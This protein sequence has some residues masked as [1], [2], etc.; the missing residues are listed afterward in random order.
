MNHT[1]PVLFEFTLQW[2]SETAN[3]CDRLFTSQGKPGTNSVTFFPAGELVPAQEN[4]HIATFPDHDFERK[5]R[6]LTIAPKIGRFYPQ[7]Y[8]WNALK[9]NRGNFQPFRIIAQADGKLTGDLNH[10]LARYPLTLTVRYGQTHTPLQ[11]QVGIPKDIATLVTENGPGMQ[12]PY[13]GVATDFYTTYPFSCADNHEDATFYNTPRLVNHLDTNAI[14]QV[15]AL[16]E[17]LLQPGM[18]VLDLMSSWVSHLPSSLENLHVTGLGMNQ[19]ELDANPRLAAR[20]MHDLNLNPLLPFA[21]ASFDAV[22]CTAS[23]EYLTRPLE[24]MHELARI[25]KPGGVVAI[26]FSTRWFPTKAITLW[27]EMHPFERQG[28][29]LD[30]FL[31]TGKFGDLHTESI[32]GLPRPENDPHI[33]QTRLSDPIFAVWGTACQ[34]C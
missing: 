1:T 22:L 4:Q 20:I 19:P 12:A 23:V 18:N 21:D 26:T 7:G 33:R 5:Q 2:K 34:L 31:K 24:V 16:Y 29:V 28:L 13:P 27:T 15:T 6:H 11:E 3:H 9:T 32:R 8:V 17:R 30:Y 10:P 25:C 14:A